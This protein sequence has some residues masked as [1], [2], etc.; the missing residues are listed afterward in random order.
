MSEAR[1]G[2]RTRDGLKA[3]PNSGRQM[4][5]AQMAL[6]KV[7]PNFMILFIQNFHRSERK[8]G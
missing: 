7:L 4:A 5:L 8:L 3:L 2:A 6:T 1:P